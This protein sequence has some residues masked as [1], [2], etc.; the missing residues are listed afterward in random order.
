MS[1]LTYVLRQR[2]PPRVALAVQQIPRKTDSE[3]QSLASTQPS[4]ARR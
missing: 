2:T 3:I 4:K 1:R